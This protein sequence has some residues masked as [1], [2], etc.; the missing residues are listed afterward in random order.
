MVN[1]SQ[2]ESSSTASTV[3]ASAS[4]STGSSVLMDTGL[5][6]SSNRKDE[7]DLSQSQYMEN[8]DML[9]TK[10]DQQFG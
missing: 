10:K 7:A 1:N 6:L 4:S 9:D 8:K 2:T 5:D 3:E